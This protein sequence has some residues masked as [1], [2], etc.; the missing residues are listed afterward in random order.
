MG[1]FIHNCLSCRLN[2]LNSHKTSSPLPSLNVRFR[3]TALPLV[4]SYVALSCWQVTATQRICSEVE[5]GFRS[6]EWL[7][8]GCEDARLTYQRVCRTSSAKWKHSTFMRVFCLL[9][10]RATILKTCNDSES[11]HLRLGSRGRFRL[12]FWRCLG[13]PLIFLRHYGI[14][15]IHLFA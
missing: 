5:I 12:L 6:G 9:F 13:F 7:V 1:C 10:M 2:V 15:R 8:V 3:Y 11:I 14:P 4:S